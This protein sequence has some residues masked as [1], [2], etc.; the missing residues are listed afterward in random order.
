MPG[1][2]PPSMCPPWLVASELT[3]HARPPIRQ[4][5]HGV[6]FALNFWLLHSGSS[7][8]TFPF[9]LFWCPYSLDSFLCDVRFETLKIPR[10]QNVSTTTVIIFAI[11]LRLLHWAEQELEEETIW[12][13]L[14]DR[15][16]LIVNL[17]YDC[18]FAEERRRQ[19]KDTEISTL[20]NAARCHSRS[21]QTLKSKPHPKENQESLSH[22]RTHRL[23]PLL[24]APLAPSSLLLLSP[25]NPSLPT[26]HL[27]RGSTPAQDQPPTATTGDQHG[28]HGQLLLD[29]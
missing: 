4:R 7:D 3:T 21:T 11:P 19:A 5:P 25:I 10:R 20:Q 23:L 12:S 27:P 2:R 29:F 18:S 24:F 1:A 16:N 17:T 13:K 15:G 28:R 8:N 14:S 9:T 22:L 26:T 6:Y